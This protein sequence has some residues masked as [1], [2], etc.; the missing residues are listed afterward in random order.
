MKVVG[1]GLL[2]ENATYD[3]IN[4]TDEDYEDHDDHDGSKHSAMLWVMVLYS[5]V[6]CVGLL[7]HA[8]LL[9]ALA[10]KRRPWSLSDIFVFNLGAADILLLLMLPFW[11]VEAT[12]DHEWTFSNP[13]C[14]ISR[15]VFNINFYCGIYLMVL[16]S[17]NGCWSST[18]RTQPCFRQKP[19]LTHFSCLLV[20]LVSLILTIPDWIFPRAE[21]DAT[22]N[23]NSLAGL[24]DIVW[25]SP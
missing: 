24:A 4:Y 20:W 25:T 14:K 2:D 13:F 19:L 17:L 3:Y 11:I 10:Q 22:Q 15:V 16:I 8:L 6:V 7:G 5:A 1:G 12:Q 21:E 18:H 23:K 9:A